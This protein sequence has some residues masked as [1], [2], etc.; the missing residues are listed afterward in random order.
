MQRM[1]ES[2]AATQQMLVAAGVRPGDVL[3]I[4][5]HSQGAM[6]GAYVAVSGEYEVQ[7]FV[8]VGNPV[9]VELSDTVD[10]VDFRHTNDP[11]AG[12]AAG[13][14][15]A[16]VGSD[17]SVV[18]TR[19]IAQEGLDP[20]YPHGLDRYVQTAELLDESDDPR[21]DVLAPLFAHLGTATAVTTTVYSARRAMPWRPGSSKDVD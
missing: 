7:T 21:A 9:T 17:E 18:V 11:V 5:G 10:S 16:G 6:I 13:R 4:A 20:F 12:L 2:Y 15:P 14:T 8:S 3:H 1:S 19:E